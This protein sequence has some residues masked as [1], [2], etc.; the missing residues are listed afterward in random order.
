[1]KSSGQEGHGVCPQHPSALTYLDLPHHIHALRHLPEHHV[2]PVQPVCFVT[3]DEELGAVG[4]WA[5]VCH[6]HHPWH[7]RVQIFIIKL[8]PVDGF[9]AGAVVV[10]EVSGLAHELGDDAVEAATFEAKSFLVGAEAAEILCV[11]VHADCPAKE[12][13]LVLQRGKKHDKAHQKV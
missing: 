9:A 6:G 12:L 8:L 3:G 13:G 11:G 5:G 4:V 7:Q 1:M 2:L 10:G